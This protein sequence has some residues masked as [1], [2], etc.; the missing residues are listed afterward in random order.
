MKTCSQL[1]NDQIDLM[2]K[3][4][5]KVIYVC[6]D[7]HDTIMPST[8]SNNDYGEYNLYK[9]AEEVLKWMSDCPHIRL[10]LFTSSYPDQKMDFMVNVYRRYGISFD[11]HNGN[12]EVQNTDTGDFSEK[13]YYNVLFDDKGGFDPQEDWLDLKQH[14]PQ[15]ECKLGI[16]T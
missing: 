2:T 15:F 13:F 9:H 12:P 6:V 3:R 1:L 5:W 10:I 7:W 11:Y 14:I 16:S 4:N 8:Y